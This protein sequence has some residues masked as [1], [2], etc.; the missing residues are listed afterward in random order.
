MDKSQ[1]RR[2]VPMFEIPSHREAL[3][4]RLNELESK[5]SAPACTKSRW[6]GGYKLVV[7][8]AACVLLITAITSL[9]IWWPSA[10]TKLSKSVTKTT[11]SQSTSVSSPSAGYANAGPSSYMRDIQAG[12]EPQLPGPAISASE[13]KA[14][15]G[16]SVRLPK[17]TVLTGKLN[18]IYPNIPPAEVLKDPNNDAHTSLTLIFANGL[19]LEEEAC[20]I[21]PD[22][23][24]E[25]AVP[26]FNGRPPD[27]VIG[28]QPI[29]AKVAGFQGMSTPEWT[30]PGTNPSKLPPQLQWWENGVRYHLIPW[31]LGYTGDELMQVASSMY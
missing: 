29:P 12:V 4:L 21:Q 11:P 2:E 27:A 26:T 23:A 20:P 1:D 30:S 15:T 22:W 7:A 13:A 5:E 8:A 3:K 17:N 16:I 6:I 28:A 31:K 19:G 10:S 25:S 18:G 9:T 14:K 24:A